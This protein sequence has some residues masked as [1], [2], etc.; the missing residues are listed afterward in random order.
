MDTYTSSLAKV[1]LRLRELWGA[2][3]RTIQL[4]IG[5]LGG[6]LIVGLGIFALMRFRGPDYGVLF[7]NLPP[8]DASAVVTKLKDVKIPYQ[9][10]NGGTTI[11]VPQ[12]NVY[13][14]RV[15]LA[16]DGVVKGGGSGARSPV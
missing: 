6:A 9:L 8:D 13:E 14:E 5:L 4:L 11:L 7:A 2:Q 3:N 1:S 15:L 10:S 16:G 12:E